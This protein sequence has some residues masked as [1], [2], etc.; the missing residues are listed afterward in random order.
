MKRPTCFGLQS[1]D[2]LPSPRVGVRAP[3][4]ASSPSSNVTNGKV[5]SIRPS[6]NSSPISRI[7]LTSRKRTPGSQKSPQNTSMLQLQVRSPISAARKHLREV[8]NDSEPRLQTRSTVKDE[9]KKRLRKRREG[10]WDR[11]G[12]IGRAANKLS[13]KYKKEAEQRKTVSARKVP[14]PPRTWPSKEEL[15][16]GFPL[17]DN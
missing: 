5:S 7:A 2:G 8:E 12:R 3:R 16:F 14:Q 1:D 15:L 10:E 13:S 6:R 11:A 4:L 17:C 9:L